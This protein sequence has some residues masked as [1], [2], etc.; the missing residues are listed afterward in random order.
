MIISYVHLLIISCASFY[1]QLCH[2][3]EL[4][5]DW[6]LLGFAVITPLSLSVGIGFRRRERALIEISRFRSYAYQL[7]L[8]H[9][10][11]DWDGLP[12]KG[13]ASH[14][15]INW[16]EHA[17]TVLT[18]LISIGDEMCRFL[19]LP[20]ASRSRHRMTKSGRREAART[21]E[22][23]DVL[24]HAICC[25]ICKLQLIFDD[26]HRLHT[27]YMILFIHNGL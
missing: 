5:M 18:E 27:D 19:T 15:D 12:P 3:L 6:V 24:Y 20:T 4:R 23:R 25:P 21:A 7:L 10:I 26:Q 8:A 11:W 17:D 16:L 22:V 1:I 14:E 2:I 9:C 13:K